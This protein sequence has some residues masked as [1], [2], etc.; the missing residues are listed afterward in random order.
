MYGNGSNSRRLCQ[1]TQSACTGGVSI[2]ILDGFWMGFEWVLN[3]FWWV[4]MGSEWFWMGFDGFWMVFEW[5]S[6]GFD[7]FWMG[8]DGFWCPVYWNEYEKDCFLIGNCEPFRKLFD[9]DRSAPREGIF[10]WTKRAS[11]ASWDSVQRTILHC[12]MR[13]SWCWKHITGPRCRCCAARCTSLP[14]RSTSRRVSAWRRNCVKCR[15]D[16]T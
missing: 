16:S 3:G 4:S 14:R 8:S 12:A 1:G 7:G 10:L 11:R 6:M 2:L 5:I 9:S 15:T 13:R